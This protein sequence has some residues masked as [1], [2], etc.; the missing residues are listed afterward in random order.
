[1]AALGSLH[2]VPSCGVGQ[3]AL[4]MHERTEGRAPCQAASSWSSRALLKAEN[5]A[6]PG[7]AL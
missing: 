4:C 3:P 5:R 6:W 2:G 7:V 1:V